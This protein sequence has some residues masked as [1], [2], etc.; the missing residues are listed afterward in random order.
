MS[1][2][3]DAAQPHRF[4]QRMKPKGTRTAEVV[5][6]RW[7]GREK[8]KLLTEMLKLPASQQQGDRQ[9][10]ICLTMFAR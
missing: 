8:Y 2:V 1:V 3:S 10:E 7:K 5:V 9:R 6:N 4:T